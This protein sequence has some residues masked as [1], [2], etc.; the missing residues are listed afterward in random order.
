MAEKQKD[1]PGATEKTLEPKKNK[2]GLIP[3]QSVDFATIQRIESKRTKK[4]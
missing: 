3:G 4:G 2:D 1:A